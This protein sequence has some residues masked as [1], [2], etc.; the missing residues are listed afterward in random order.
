MSSYRQL[1]IEERC[2]IA[3]LHEGGQ[4]IRQIAAALDRQPSTISRELNRNKGARIGYSPTYAQ[5]QA[6]ARR[7]S[8][9]R[10]ERDDALREKILDLLALGWSPEQICGR[11]A[12]AVVGGKLRMTRTEREE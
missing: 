5:Q 1:S 6:A 3:R 11:L 4:S 9:S 12:F 10:L 2:E 8:G 7:W